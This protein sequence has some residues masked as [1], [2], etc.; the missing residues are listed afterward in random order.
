MKPAPDGDLHGTLSDEEIASCYGIAYR[1]ARR[2]GASHHDAEDVAQDSILKALGD[3]ASRRIEPSDFRRWIVGIARKRV[4][5]GRRSEE[6][7]RE[8]Q[9]RHELGRQRE[10]LPAESAE[11]ALGWS[12]VANLIETLSPRRRDCVRLMMA[13]MSTNEIAAQLEIKAGTVRTT[14]AA[15]YKCLAEMIDRTN[16]ELGRPEG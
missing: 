2:A 12:L 10:T 15:A 16:D 7:R 4:A 5:T 9:A 1:V 8:R 13:G 6:R 11:V 14:L 3:I